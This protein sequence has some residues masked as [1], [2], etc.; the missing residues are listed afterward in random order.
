MTRKVLELKYWLKSQKYKDGAAV[1]YSTDN[2]Q[3]LA[4]AGHPGY[5]MELV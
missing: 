5:R 1:D 3:Y 4:V 2:G